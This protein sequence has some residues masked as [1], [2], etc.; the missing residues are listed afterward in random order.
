VTAAVLDASV[1][2]AALSPAEIHHREARALYDS[3]DERRAFL[4]PSLFCVEVIAAL[5]RRGEPE[6]VLDTV[7]VLVSGPRF[8]SVAIDDSLIETAIRVAR[9]ARLRAYDSVY[10]SL[11]L[12]RNA[13]LLTLDADVRSKLGEVFPTLEFAVA[14]P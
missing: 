13:A 7:G 1:F 12:S 10:A 5:A 4:V 9:S 2:V 14:R 3:Y 11:A 6:E 8:H